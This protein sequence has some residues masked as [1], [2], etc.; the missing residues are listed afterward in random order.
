[1]TEGI[2]ERTSVDSSGKIPIFYEHVRPAEANRGAADDT[3]VR[4]MK[5]LRDWRQ[6][7]VLVFQISVFLTFWTSHREMAYRD[8]HMEF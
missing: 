4:T 7:G 2:A 6:I 1:M 8:K 3:Y 5:S